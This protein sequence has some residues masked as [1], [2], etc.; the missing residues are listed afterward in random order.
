MGVLL[1]TTFGPAEEGVGPCLV[2]ERDLDRA[3]GDGHAEVEPF[4][5]H[6]PKVEDGIR[7]SKYN[8]KAFRA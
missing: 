2:V 6:R 3:A 7:G 4:R 5:T 8:R 1:P